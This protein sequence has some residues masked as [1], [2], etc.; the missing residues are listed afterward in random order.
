MTAVNL[1]L[2]DPVNVREENG[3]IVIEPIPSP[4]YRLEKLLA[5][6]TSKNV[7]KAIDFGKAIG[8]ES[9]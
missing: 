5:G 8:K 9:F 3:R 1:R 6:I 7:H 2:N 4:V